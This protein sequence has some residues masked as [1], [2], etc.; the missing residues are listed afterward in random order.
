MRMW[1]RFQGKISHEDKPDNEDASSTV[2][3]ESDI[4][5]P[6]SKRVPEEDFKC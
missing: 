1:K 4:S 2:I 6:F 3:V 5:E